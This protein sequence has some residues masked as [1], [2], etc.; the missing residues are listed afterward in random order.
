MVHK[1]VT[2]DKVHGETLDAIRA[3]GI[4]VIVA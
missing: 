2:D 4:E 3:M 1:I